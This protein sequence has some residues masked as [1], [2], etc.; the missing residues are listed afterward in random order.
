MVEISD[1]GFYDGDLSKLTGI[2]VETGQMTN[3]LK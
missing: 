2:S 3:L 1:A